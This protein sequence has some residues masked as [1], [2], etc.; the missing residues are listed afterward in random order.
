MEGTA[1]VIRTPRWQAFI[2]ACWVAWATCLLLGW[3]GWG[4]VVALVN[5]GNVS[6]TCAPSG[7]AGAH[8]VR[9]ERPG[10][11]EASP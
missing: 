1:A 10:R 4:L 9:G 5:L 3:Y 6:A 11:T 7:D 8:D 2:I